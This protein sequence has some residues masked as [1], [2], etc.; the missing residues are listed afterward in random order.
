MQHFYHPNYKLELVFS[1]I[2]I[3]FLIKLPS[4]PFHMWLTEAHAETST[5]RSVLLSRIVLK[6]RGFRIYKFYLPIARNHYVLFN[7]I[8]ILITLSVINSRY[9]ALS[10]NNLKQFIAY[11]SILHM[12]ISAVSLFLN[13]VSSV[14][15]SLYLMCGHNITSSSL[16]IIADM[17][18]VRSKTYQ[19]SEFNSIIYKAPLL[20]FFICIF[21]FANISLPFTA[22]FVGK[23][24]IFS[25]LFRSGYNIIIFIIIFYIL[26]SSSAS[27]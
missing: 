10:S 21:L 5:S 23:F 2:L 24:I 6:L 12:N 13:K 27:I 9:C 7:L 4:Y 1:S 16:S 11:N 20:S 14:T 17:L 26:I 3:A 15:R 25:D 18:Y 19:I 22:G 8:T